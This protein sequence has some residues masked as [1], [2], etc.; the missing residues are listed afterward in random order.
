MMPS[1]TRPTL[2]WASIALLVSMVTSAHGEPRGRRTWGSFVYP[3]ARSTRHIPHRLELVDANHDGRAELVR[4]FVRVKFEAP[5]QWAIALPTLMTPEGASD[6]AM[7]VGSSLGS[8]QQ[9]PPARP[10]HI[11]LF[12]L[13]KQESREVGIEFDAEEIRAQLK[14]RA[15]M[16]SLSVN[17][18]TSAE[19]IAIGG[20]SYVSHVPAIPIDRLGWLPARIVGVQPYIEPGRVRFRVRLEADRDTLCKFVMMAFLTSRSGRADSTVIVRAPAGTSEQELIL[21]TPDSFVDAPQDSVGLHIRVGE[22][23]V[24][25][26]SGSW[27]RAPALRVRR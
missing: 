6:V 26:P 15:A 20:P 24:F 1:C 17:R 7:V 22:R 3:P 4:V 27:G 13:V 21:L 12:T 18:V 23:E 2:R 14:G 19:T 5:G 25:V 8:V 9:G 10:Q 11:L 16:L